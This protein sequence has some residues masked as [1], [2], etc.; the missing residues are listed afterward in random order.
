MVFN[1]VNDKAMGSRLKNL[2]QEKGL[3]QK[4]V[5]ESLSLRLSTYQKYEEGVRRPSDSVKVQLAD[6]F[7]VSVQY[8]FFEI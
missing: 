1:I 4:E 5:S 7:E 6:F 3:T 2:R 8:L